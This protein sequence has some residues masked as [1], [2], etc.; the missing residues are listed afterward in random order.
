MMSVINQP[1]VD[2]TGQPDPSEKQIFDPTNQLAVSFFKSG[3]FQPISEP[4]SETNEAIESLC[5]AASTGDL[6][7]IQMHIS[8]GTPIN[9]TNSQRLNPL[10]Y[11]LI[12]GQLG[13][14]ILLG[15]S[16]SDLSQITQTTQ[17]NILHLAAIYGHAHIIFHLLE[18]GFEINTRDKAGYTALHHAVEN[19]KSTAFNTLLMKQADPNLPTIL[20]GASPLHIASATGQV[21]MIKSLILSGAEVNARDGGQCTPLHEAAEHGHLEAVETLLKMGA[22]PNARNT[23]GRTPLHKAAEKDNLP[24][25]EKL[26]NGKADVNAMDDEKITPLLATQKLDT[27]KL[28]RRLAISKD[29]SKVFKTTNAHIWA[30]RG[31]LDK[32]QQLTTEELNAQDENGHTPLHSAFI[33]G[34]IGAFDTLIKLGA[35]PKIPDNYWNTPED[36][37]ASMEINPSTLLEDPNKH[38]K[39][40]RERN[41]TKITRRTSSKKK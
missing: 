6:T 25:I 35:D 41:S 22:D 15:K 24:I 33:A 19:K 40:P 11:A 32:L 16:G 38:R 14:L 7:T 17:K 13:A 12:N 3:C 34:R 2:S 5:N 9:G 18:N 37:R 31:E 28:L 36:L 27:K 23:Y 21:A 39:R 1:I 8:K 29:G 26:L 30:E 4:P 10:Q 20:F